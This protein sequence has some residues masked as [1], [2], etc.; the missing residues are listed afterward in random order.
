MA[1]CYADAIGG[2]KAEIDVVTDPAFRR[3]GLGRQAVAGFM[4]TC[5]AVGLEP[6]WDCF[7]NNIPSVRTAQSLGFRPL[8]A[9]YDFFTIPRRGPDGTNVSMSSSAETF[10]S[11]G[12]VP[13][14][15]R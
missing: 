11:A 14:P 9:P 2:G 15:T 12:T 1:I 13:P 5:A 8:G 10:S 6:V 3:Q 4:T 7:T